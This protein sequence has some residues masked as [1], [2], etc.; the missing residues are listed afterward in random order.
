MFGPIKAAITT[1]RR[2]VK[3]VRKKSTVAHSPCIGQDL[4]SIVT[5]LAVAV[6]WEG[7]IV[8][9]EKST[10]GLEMENTI[11]RFI[12]WGLASELNKFLGAF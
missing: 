8:D 11:H 6:P 1:K 4:A 7:N 2:E 9:G 5:V 3:L 12:V 10:I